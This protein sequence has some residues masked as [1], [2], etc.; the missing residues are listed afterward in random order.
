MVIFGET[1]ALLQN[2]SVVWLHTPHGS[3]QACMTIAIVL[4]TSLAQLTAV[5]TQQQ[6]PNTHHNHAWSLCACLRST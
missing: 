3:C 4:C 5:T 1:A 2:G 6:E